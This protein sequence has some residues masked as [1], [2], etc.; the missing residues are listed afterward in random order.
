MGNAPCSWGAL[1]LEGAAGGRIGYAQMLDELVATGYTGTELG[2]WGFMPTDPLV[3]RRELERRRLT[4]IGAYVPV[5][6]KGE[7]AHAEGAERAVRVARLLASVRG[8]AGDDH[9]P[10]LVLADDNGTDPVRTRSAGRIRPDM[11]LS[12]AEWATF[13]AGAELVARAVRDETGLPL[14]FHHHCAGWVETPDEIA[15]FLEITDPELVG[16]CF[17]TGHYAYGSGTTDRACVPTGL[18]RFADR[19][20]Y[21]QLKDCDPEVARRARAEGWDHLEAVRHGLF[22]ELG[23]GMVDLPAV[24]DWL[25]RR[26]HRGWVL[27]EQDVLPGMGTPRESAR[28]NREHLRSIGL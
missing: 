25:I 24:R 17:D 10:F 14:V 6:L 16:L 20:R 4:M 13:A 26:G 23:K 3:L 28:R 2:D 12:D 9:L 18:E 22:C 11:S 5:R 15:R 7:R 8:T 1:E 27:V 19:I 21:V